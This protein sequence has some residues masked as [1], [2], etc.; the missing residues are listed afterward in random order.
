[1]EKNKE[2]KTEQKPLKEYFTVKIEALAPVILTYKILAE[3]PEEAAESAAKK[4]GQQ[5]SS[6]PKI[7]FAKLGKMKVKVYKSGTTL[8]RLTKNI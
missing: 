5:Q 4:Q 3:T 2:K 7:I 1:M 8:L 6:P